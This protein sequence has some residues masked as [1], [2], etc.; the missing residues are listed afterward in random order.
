MRGQTNLRTAANASGRKLQRET[1]THDRNHNMG[2]ASPSVLETQSR[3][4]NAQ[5]SRRDKRGLFASL[6]TAKAKIGP[7]RHRNVIVGS[8]SGKARA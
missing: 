8:G 5:P 3:M 2:V 4:S 7:T 1:L 6:G